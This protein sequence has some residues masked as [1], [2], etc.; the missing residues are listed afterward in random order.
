MTQP[1][2]ELTTFIHN[3][4]KAEIHVHLEGAIQPKTALALARR[5]NKLDALPGQD[6]A[7]LR[8]WFIFTGFPHFLDVYMTIQDLLRT[9]ED[10]ALI[11]YECGQDMAAQNIRYREVTF[12]PFTHTDYLDKGLRIDDILDGLE[13]GRQRAQAEFGVEMR[14]VF[15]IPRNCSFPNDDG[16]AYDPRPAER[17]LEF[18]LAGRSKGVVGFGLGGNEVNAPP[19]PFADAFVAAKTAGL[20]SV[21]HAGETTGPASIWG[22]LNE[23]QADRIGHGVRAIE[24]PQLLT[25]LKERQ[26][27]LEINPTS[28]VCLGVYRQSAVHPF[29]HLDRMGL[30]VTVNSDDPPLFNT[31]LT[32]EY[33]LL[34]REFGYG[35]ADLARIARNA[36]AAAA[37]EPPVKQKLL[38]EFDVWLVK[39]FDK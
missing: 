23:L 25:V 24:D 38:A 22:A 21:P 5:H 32:R 29:P 27:P 30:L 18:A 2:S 36:F 35:R 19:Q 3:M 10:F 4:P 17:T 11:A 13:N 14:W 39:Q 16:I 34:A 12:T 8:H 37:A 15:D 1:A 6:V 7:A 28:N 26:I 31:T 20:V 9:P 33:E